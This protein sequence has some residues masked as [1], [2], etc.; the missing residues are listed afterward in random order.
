MI[1]S[2]PNINKDTPIVDIAYQK[3]NGELF[4]DVLVHPFN[5][6]AVEILLSAYMN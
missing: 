3:K 4:D 6:E 1:K 5:R 2:I